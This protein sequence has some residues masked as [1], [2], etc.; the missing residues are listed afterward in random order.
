MS[1]AAVLT[2]FNPRSLAGATYCIYDR[3]GELIFQ[4]TLPRGSDRIHFKLNLTSKNFNPRSLAGA[5]TLLARLTVTTPAFQSTLPRG[6]DRFYKGDRVAQFI[7]IHAPSRE[8]PGSYGTSGSVTNFNPRSLAGA[9]KNLLRCLLS[10]IFQS[11]LPRGSD[12]IPSEL[13]KST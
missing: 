11:T 4:S 10:R 12:L 1:R 6:S 3:K 5:T 7:S 13:V 8:R 2:D 9:T